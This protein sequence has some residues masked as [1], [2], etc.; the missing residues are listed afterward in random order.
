[1]F[2]IIFWTCRLFGGRSPQAGGA[3]FSL[4]SFLLRQKGGSKKDEFILSEAEV[5]HSL[6]LQ[7]TINN[8]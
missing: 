5:L 6:T 3:G 8:E 4:Q 1:M 7:I 2:Q